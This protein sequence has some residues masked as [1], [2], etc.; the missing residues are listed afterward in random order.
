MTN[1][2]LPKIQHSPSAGYPMLHASV[3]RTAKGT[4]YLQEPGV[5]VNAAPRTDL[6]G[7]R[8]FLED[9]GP[10]LNFAQYLND[11]T[12]LP[13]ATQ[14]VKVSG[15]ACYASFSPKR[16]TNADADR[17]LDNIL[18]S[19][20]G[21]VLEHANYSLFVYGVSRSL[22]HELIRHRAG[23]GFSQLSQRYVSGRVLRFVERP[24]FAADPQLHAEFEADIDHA[25]ERYESTAQR[26][27]EQQAA[28]LG[29][30]S[31]DQK[32]DLRKKV[33]QAARAKLPNETETFLEVT[34][35]ARAWRHIINMRA[36]EH[37]ETEIRALAVAV[38]RL[39]SS[40]D[41]LIFAD[42][43]LVRHTDGTYIVKTKYEKV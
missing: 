25:A 15:Q 10:E 7:M 19:G 35:N 40:M 41:P 16:T 9:F 43:D 2:D 14:L 17:Y 5:L 8:D 33:Q 22:T 21:S 24:E 1:F 23:M 42:M 28:G 39:L 13:D 37:A 3:H 18:S 12:K 11:S 27:F 4:P 32:T 6:S 26:L 29:I 38:Y 34:G 31:A 20:H 36:N 30:L